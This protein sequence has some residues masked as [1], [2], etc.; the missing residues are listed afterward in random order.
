MATRV[1]RTGRSL[2]PAITAALLLGA[3]AAWAVLVVQMRGMD[4]GP[5]TDLR[6]LGWFLGV[7]VTMTA[8]MMLPSAVPMV[9]VYARVAGGSS[10]R[11]LASTAGF[12]AG[13]LIAWAGYGL[14]AYGLYR[15]VRALDPA[16][17]AWDRQ[18]PYVAGGAIIVAGAYQLTP[19]KRVCLRHCRTPFHYV[20]HGWRTGPLGPVRMGVEHG[21]YCVGCCW[22]L[23]V[24][25]FA[26]G[27]MSLA[28]MA[29]VAAI[30]FAEKV[31]PIGERLSRVFAVALIGLGIWVA[32]APAS[33]PW[34]HQPGMGMTQMAAGRT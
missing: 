11:P 29:V 17:L 31:L 14:A 20:I 30:I 26:V 10:Q 16:F 6:S 24:V 15:L 32:V 12:L 18:G 5:G 23:M 9:R 1:R 28:W 3:L 34:M 7:W 4:D 22:A 25:L 8:A 2:G 19:L 21:G 27:V 33:V 13:Y